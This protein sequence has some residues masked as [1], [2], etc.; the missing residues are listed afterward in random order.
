MKY[1]LFF[2]GLF[3]SFQT[4]FS[5]D[6]INGKI[7][8]SE[9]DE[10]LS[11]VNIVYNSRGFGTVSNIDGKF[12]VP[13]TSDVEFL[14]FSYLGYH[15]YI[16]DINSVR[17]SRDLTIK[18]D[19]KFYDINEVSVTPGINPAHRIIYK[20]IE[21]RDLNNPEKMKSFSCRA[22]N[23]MYFTVQFDTTAVNKESD[24]TDSIVSRIEIDFDS[25]DSSL[26]KTM[27]FFENQYLFLMES[28]SEREF[29]YP[30]NNKEVVTAS[31]V[32]GFNDPSFTMLAT[33][34]QSFAFYNDLIMIWDKKYINPIS[35][36]SPGRYLF[37]LEDTIF[38]EQND[39]LFIIS[40]RPLRGRN[41]DGLKGILHINSNGYAI[42]DVIAEAAEQEG[43]IRIRIRQKYDWIENQQ[44]F[45]V[46]LNTDIILK[47]NEMKVN[48]MP[49]SLLGT[50]KSY[51]SDIVLNPE[52]KKREFSPVELSVENDAQLKSDD[53]WIKYRVIPLSSKDTNTY[54]IIDS[55]GKEAKLDRSVAI[56]ETL[57]SG[58]IPWNY[59]D[60]NFRSIINY[61]NYEGFR[62]GLGI[63]T[64]RKLSD[65]FNIGG[66][67]AWGTCDKDFKYGGHLKIFIDPVTE[68]FIQYKYNHDVL[69]SA[70]F[71]FLDN[72][73]ITSSENF[74]RFFIQN[75]D[76]VEEHEIAYGS[77]MIRH[78]RFNIFLNHSIK[79]VTSDYR[80]VTE[81]DTSASSS[82][83]RFT[84]IGARF[85]F[86]Y[87]EKF[88][89][90]PRGNRISIGT[91][92]P[93]LNFNVIKG[94]K[95]LQGDYEYFKFEARLSK[96]FITK[97]FGNTI[98]TLSGGLTDGNIPYPNIYNGYGSYGK[99][100]PEVENSF[101]TMRMNEFVFDRFVFGFFQ[102]DF[103][104]LLFKKGK[105]RPGIVL[106]TNAGYGRLLHKSNHENIELNTIE[107]GYYESGILFKNLLRQ[108]FIG[109]GVGAF[110]RYGPY[111]LNKTIDN[112]AF[113]FTI[114]FNI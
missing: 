101:G 17:M 41:F 2:T 1:L 71:K 34:V 3:L 43:M 84:E 12:S 32:S 48:G 25:G 29:L 78:F 22:Y 33:Q 81:N 111:S 112:F 61:N 113:K 54:R 52:I 97:S 95:W 91:K 82:I 50:G 53:Y 21:N 63:Q 72:I 55:I 98:I 86:A 75:K 44:W 103:S 8:D 60:I 23:K 47:T 35:K 30:D 109:Y 85:R 83:F 59:L 9:S 89:E 114:S 102:Q 74:R 104:S 96:K 18:L 69:E 36:G 5:Q 49:A 26:T 106:V 27:N 57:A 15:S 37:I 90:T 99:F 68:S 56:I 39:T 92:Y 88:I 45:P 93:I 51:I 110:Y 46:E 7:T 14:K 67:F 105:F 6:Y 13:L 76:L 94:L 65:W 70:G 77:S 10:P 20:A 42:Q 58:Y 107:N 73:P 62:L 87:K 19:P 79:E 4:A 40:F 24:K 16:M 28:V 66:H 38:T 11:F 64:N 100:A 31:R 108:W 80:F